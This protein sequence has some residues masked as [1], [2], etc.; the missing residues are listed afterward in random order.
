MAN[1]YTNAEMADMHF[2]NGLVDCKMRSTVLT[3]N[4][5]PAAGSHKGVH[6]A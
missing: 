2:M 4:G 1:K 6:S 3:K 5:S